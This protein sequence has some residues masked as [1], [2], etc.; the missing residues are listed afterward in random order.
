MRPKVEAR[1]VYWQDS[2]YGLHCPSE[3]QR[4]FH[5]YDVS[6]LCNL[7]VLDLRGPGGSGGRISTMRI[8]MPVCS[9]MLS[10]VVMRTRVM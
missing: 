7:L 9:E 6:V 2:H 5:E 3:D 4:L 1:G 10:R 8:L